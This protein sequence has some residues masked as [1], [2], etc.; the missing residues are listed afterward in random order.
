MYNIQMEIS[1]YTNRSGK[2]PVDE[3]IAN[4][5][6][7]VRS[8][9]LRCLISIQ[10]VGLDCPFVEF[11]QID[12]KL[13]EIK[14]KTEAGGYRLFYVCIKNNLLVLLHAYKKQSQRAPAKEID[15][16][17]KRLKEVVSDESTYLR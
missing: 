16:A 2:V 15:I 13:W 6:K 17:Q 14:I 3:Y 12:G 9:I 10:E 7:T 1:F 5:Q 11:R 8:K 4:L